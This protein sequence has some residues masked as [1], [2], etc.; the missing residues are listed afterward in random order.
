MNII[1]NYLV[2][3]GKYGD[4][5]WVTMGSAMFDDWTWLQQNEWPGVCK[6]GKAQSPI[7]IESSATTLAPNMRFVWEYKSE[8]VPI[9]KYNGHEQVIEGEF[10]GFTHQLEVGVRKYHAY[11]MT[12]KFPGEHQFDGQ[13]FDGEILVYHKSNNGLKA[14]VSFLVSEVP[15]GDADHNKFVEGL[16]VEGWEFNP[17]KGYRLDARPS[18]DTLVKGG[19]HIYMQKT[20]YWYMGSDSVPECEQEINRFVFKQVIQVPATQ[21]QAWKEKTY[22]AES[23]ERGNSRR[24]KKSAGRLVYYHVDKSK[25]CKLASDKIMEASEDMIADAE[26]SKDKEFPGKW[27]K[28]DT[29]LHS[30]GISW[31]KLSEPIHLENGIRVENVQEGDVPPETRETLRKAELRKRKELTQQAMKDH[32]IDQSKVRINFT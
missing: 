19:G 8:D 27:L 22:E 2:E 26:A 17:S 29:S 18:P 12:F 16:D 32:G 24:A 11:K 23:E 3:I 30:Y 25:N 6:D 20:F 7:D 13:E 9:A 4:M 1:K 28:A 5:S 21:F 14:I 15:D 10:G 31:Q